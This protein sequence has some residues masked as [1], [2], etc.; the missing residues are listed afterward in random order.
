[1]SLLTGNLTNFIITHIFG[2]K[3]IDFLKPMI[4]A[5]VVAGVIVLV[6]S[7]VFLKLEAKKGQQQH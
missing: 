4:V 7:F 1:M 5:G 3:F 6:Y 2:I